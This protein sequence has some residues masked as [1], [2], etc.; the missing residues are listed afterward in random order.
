MEEK[1]KKKSG[2]Y[3]WLWFS[4]VLLLIIG[5]VLIYKTKLSNMDNI[6]FNIGVSMISTAI[7]TTLLSIGNQY[8]EN[9]KESNIVKECSNTI[10]NS[11]Q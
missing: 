7:I 11:F 5:G 9:T 6:L 1:M 8:I 3:F 10:R 4:V 2:T